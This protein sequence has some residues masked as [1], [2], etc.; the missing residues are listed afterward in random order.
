M[1]D[2]VPIL[3]AFYRGLAPDDRGRMIQEI[4]AW[5]HAVLERVHDYIQWLFPLDTPSRFNPGAPVLD[6]R[7]IRIFRADPVIQTNLLSSLD[8]MLGFYGFTRA[9]GSDPPAIIKTDDFVKRRDCWLNRHNHNFLRITRILR[10][11]RLTGREDLARAF[12]KALEEIFFAEE[13][14]TIG[15]TTYGFWREAAGCVEE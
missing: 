14:Q 8:V 6:G 11:L 4:W 7:S 9:A 10:C 3:A 15:S 13:M 1:P 2:A 12:F 5:D